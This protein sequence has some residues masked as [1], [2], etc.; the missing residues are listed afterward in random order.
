MFFSDSA[1]SM[2]GSAVTLYFLQLSYAPDPVDRIRAVRRL[3]REQ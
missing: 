1:K 2:L 3:D